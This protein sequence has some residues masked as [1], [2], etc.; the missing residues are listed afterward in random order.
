MTE[1][2]RLA[3]APR[4]YRAVFFDLDGTL[5]PMELEGFMTA[6]FQS[7]AAFVGAHGLDAQAF[8][9][10]LKAGIGAMATH[11]D[12]RTNA[13]AFWGAFFQE[14]D[15]AEADWEALLGEFYEVDFGKIGEGARP[16]PA[17]ARAVNALAEKGY[18][19]VLATMPMFP[20]RA[21]EWRLAWAGVDARLF[22]RLTTYENSTSVKPKPAYCAETSRH[23]GWRARTCS[24]WATTRWKTRRSPVWAPT[25]TWSPTICWIRRARV[26]KGCATGRWRISPPSRRRFPRAPTRF[27]ASSRAWFP[28]RRG[29]RRLP[30][31]R[32]WRQATLCGRWKH[33]TR[34]TPVPRG[35]CAA[36]SGRK[37]R[38][39]ALFDCTCEARSGHARALSYETVH[40]TFRTPMF[41]PV[42]T[43][44]SV[45]G[46]T[47]GQLR[48][49]DAQVVLANT[50]HLS[51]RPG[52]DVVPRPEACMRSC[53]TTAPC[54]PIRA[55]SRCSA[56]PTR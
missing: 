10:G 53:T 2:N 52:A 7:I 9:A 17:A 6:Y 54:S 23:A 32:G 40:G 41:M 31:T 18:P 56:W 26:W 44:A 13:E 4:A 48:D 19:L 45:K 34:S 25:C 14:A 20:R 21:V 29:R 12:G 11:E 28:P 24:W 55:A 3:A 38:A 49:L 22:S 35:R 42:G 47:V 30:R 1:P 16:N 5:L 33:P 50:Y 36:R 46:V 15:A 51:L 37:P 8:S 43:S 27:R 39:M